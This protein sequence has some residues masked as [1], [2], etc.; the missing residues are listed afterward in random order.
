III[1]SLENHSF[2]TYKHL[3]Y[4]DIRNLTLERIQVTFNQN[5]KTYTMKTLICTIVVS[6]FFSSGLYAKDNDTII[7]EAGV[8]ALLTQIKLETEY[9]MFL[10]LKTNDT[11][12]VEKIKAYNL[13]RLR[14][15]G[16]INQLSADLIVK[17]KL[18]T[19][20]KL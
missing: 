1:K 12:V 7:N 4:F 10:S 3:L 17:N 8:V 6:L 18:G 5:L 13:V 11:V 20:K 14:V 9:A 2:F 16:L 19:Y 15:D